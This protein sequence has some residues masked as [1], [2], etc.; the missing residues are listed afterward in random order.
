M[1]DATPTVGSPPRVEIRRSS[2]RKR[3]VTA[4]RE[5]DAIVVL[6]PQR[7]SEAEERRIVDD[8]V[9]RVLAREAKRAAPEGDEDLMAR[10]VDLATEHLVPAVGR[11][12]V[13]DSVRWV[14]NQHR[15]WGS[16]TPSTGTIRLSHR[17]QTMP[18]WVV[19]YVLVH[20]LTHLVEHDHSPRFWALVERYPL[21]QRARG[22]LEGYAAAAGT[23]GEG[24]G[25]V[26]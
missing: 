18:S 1:Q 19:D 3:T 15:R 23:P 2:R 4:Y 10:A 8:L 9:R 7:M 12:V 16:C 5:Q 21:A 11:P 22:Y 20:E 24:P 26:D 14:T 17:L 13:A 6:V 25:D